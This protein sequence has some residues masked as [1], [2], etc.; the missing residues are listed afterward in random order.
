MNRWQKVLLSIGW[1]GIFLTYTVASWSSASEYELSIYHN[2]PLLFWVGVA[3]AL[4]TSIYSVKFQRGIIRGTGVVIGMLAI[5]SVVSI[6]YLRGYF[7]YGRFDSLSHLG[8]VIDMLS[9]AIAVNE[10]MYPGTHMFAVAL[11]FSTGLEP[12]RS[13]LLLVMIFVLLFFLT[14]PLASYYL[15]DDSNVRN[16]SWL[17]ALLLL[18]VLVVR[19]PRFEPTPTLLALLFLPTCVIIVLQY[20]VKKYKANRLLAIIAFVGLTLYHPQQ[21]V[22][23]VGSLAT[24]IIINSIG[25]RLGAVANNHNQLNTI[26]VIGI[27][28]ISVWLSNQRGFTGAVADVIIGLQSN[29]TGS[30]AAPQGESV[31]AVGLSLFEIFIRT[32]LVEA[33]AAI[34]VAILVFVFLLPKTRPSLPI[35]YRPFTLL[36]V[37]IAP[38]SVF[39]VIFFAIGEQSQFL[40]Y[41]SYMLVIGTILVPI[42]LHWITERIFVRRVSTV[43]VTVI[44]IIAFLA[45][46]PALHSSPYV[47]QSNQQITEGQVEGYKATFEYQQ[48]DTTIAGVTTSVFRHRN[49]IYGKAI[50]ERGYYN[51]QPVTRAIKPLN[52]SRSYWR[53][54]YIHYHFNNQD[55]PAGIERDTYV[56]TTDRDYK[57]RVGLYGG[58]AYTQDDFDYLNRDPLISKPI[59]NGNAEV[60]YVE[61]TRGR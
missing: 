56:V 1:F 14:A 31:E 39:L 18:P 42:G 23:F 46:V 41:V 2:T 36:T 34:V 58:L 25:R 30:G 22:V 10:V 6:P 59:S 11:S 17:V 38:A 27:V 57:D 55:L 48:P 3:I 37:M 16:T 21:A 33:V 35:R 40:R 28:V 26:T 15:T 44:L 45:T 12:R 43:I 54:S 20:F 60:Y 13:L 7:Y 61:S 19:I 51:L 8:T 47:F 32:L 24:F 9:G 53:H 52:N 50:S 5:I 29:P 4:T 49:A